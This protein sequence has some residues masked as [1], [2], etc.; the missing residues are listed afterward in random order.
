LKQASD[1]VS[2]LRTLSE[3]LDAAKSVGLDQRSLS[4]DLK[5]KIDQVATEINAAANE[6]N[7]R[8]DSNSDK[9]ADVLNTM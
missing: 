7:S 2:N 6:L 4:S 8:T 5:L 1:T 9:I 3:T